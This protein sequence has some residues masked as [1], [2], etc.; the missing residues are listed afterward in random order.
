MDKNI[1]I[2]NK[3]KYCSAW[4]SKISKKA[5]CN[6][7]PCCGFCRHGKSDKVSPGFND[8]NK[9]GKHP[10]VDGK[11]RFD[12]GTFYDPNFVLEHI[13]VSKTKHTFHGKTYIFSNKNLKEGDKVFPISN[14]FI[15]DD[16]KYYHQEFDFRKIISGFPNEPHI[17]LNLKY[18][19]YK[20][21]EIRT[22][23]GYGP[24]ESYFKI[25]NIIK[26]NRG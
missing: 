17:I 6:V 24:I 21:Y 10:L 16:K 4:V 2:E 9:V 13:L 23:K 25:I 12:D 1:K 7:I 20:P 15:G 22:N 11:F 14:G 3:P 8:I 26:I 5:M 19:N 18:S